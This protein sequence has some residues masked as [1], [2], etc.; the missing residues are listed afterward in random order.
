MGRQNFF[1]QKQKF[2]MKSLIFL[3]GLVVLAAATEIEDPSEVGEFEE[4]E[5]DEFEERE[6]EE[7]EEFEADEREFEERGV[8]NCHGFCNVIDLA[9]SAQISTSS[10]YNVGN[11]YSLKT[12]VDGC[13]GTKVTSKNLNTCCFH[14][15][16]SDLNGLISDSANPSSLEEW[17]SITEWIAAK[18]GFSPWKFS[19]ATKRINSPN[20]RGSP[21]KSEIP[22]FH[23]WIQ[24]QSAL[25]AAP[26][27]EH[28]LQ[29][30]SKI[31]C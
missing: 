16:K 25:I 18:D 6:L 22:K 10:T 27:G 5:F 26:C 29:F 17:S 7:S 3:L 15:K 11:K 21:S 19:F 31:R 9:K 28:P 8:K 30:G 23:R 2:N 12:L 24:I 13:T 1:H 20:V 14:T 4:K